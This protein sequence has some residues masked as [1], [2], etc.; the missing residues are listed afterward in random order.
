[1]K[2]LVELI[3]LKEDI[4]LLIEN[5]LENLTEQEIIWLTENKGKAA[6]ELIKGGART[7]RS[8]GRAL[9]GSDV[10]AA[11]S[12]LDSSVSTA[13]TAARAAGKAGRAQNRD[14]WKAVGKS[15][16]EKRAAYHAAQEASRR[17]S[18]VAIGGLGG[19]GAVSMG[20]DIGGNML[21]NRKRR[22]EQEWYDS[23][24]IHKKAMVNA[25]RAYNKLRN[26]E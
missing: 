24:P 1:M 17:A 8:F 21:K 23:L 26:G 19:F 2:N 14:G 16:A 22:Q 4:D 15:I 5:E 12:A 10:R 25:R 7:V 18:N 11:K 13:R 3:Q 6:L 20:S 9:S